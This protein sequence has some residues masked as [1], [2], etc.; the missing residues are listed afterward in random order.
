MSDPSDVDRRTWPSPIIS[1]VYPLSSQRTLD[2]GVVSVQCLF[3]EAAES[4]SD[5]LSLDHCISFVH[6]YGGGIL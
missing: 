1:A 5:V 4:H 6:G 3:I 2:R